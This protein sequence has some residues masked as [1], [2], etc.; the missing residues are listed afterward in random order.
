MSR[1][2]EILKYKTLERILN[3]SELCVVKS[4]IGLLRDSEFDE[5]WRFD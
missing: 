2:S 5:L 4:P 1:L 3:V